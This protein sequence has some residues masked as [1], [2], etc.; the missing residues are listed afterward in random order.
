[1]HDLPGLQFLA[2]Q[3]DH[4]RLAPQV[5]VARQIAH[6]ANRD[7]R[8]GGGDRHAAAVTVGQCDHVIDVRVLGQQLI[9]DAF[10]RV[11]KHAGH[12]LHGGGDPENIARANSAVSVAI[13]LESEAFER[14]LSV[15]HLG[16]ERQTVQ[17]RRGRHA[18]LI[19]LDP[20]ATGDRLQCVANDLAV[21]NHVPA[22]GNVLQ[23]DLVA[24]RHK[25]H[26]HQ[27]I[28]KLSTGRYPLVIDHNHYIVPLVQADVARRVGMFNQLHD[29]A[30]QE[31][32]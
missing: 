29:A 2:T 19:F 7:V 6:R 1:M 22:L 16:G 24:L 20:T 4:Q 8:V 10:Y 26:R 9:L 17:R 27:A 12:A 13:P 23:R 25:I 14:R 5:R 18:Q 21:A 28:R 31:C 30:P 11:I 3:A 15:R 32:A